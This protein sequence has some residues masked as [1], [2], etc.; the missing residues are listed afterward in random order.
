MGRA[1]CIS[2]L[3]MLLLTVADSAAIAQQK[4][5]IS[6]ESF[7]WTIE[8][9]PLVFQG[10]VT[11]VEVILIT[12]KEV[13]GVGNTTAQIP[14]TEVTMKIEKI[15]AGEYDGD[16]IRIILPEGETEKAS[17]GPAGVARM[18]VNVGDHA[19]VAFTLDS[20]GTGLN[21]LDRDER[22]FRMEGTELIPYRQ[23]LYLAVDK[24][25]EVMAKK[26]KER[27]IT[28]VFK[29]SDLICTGTVTQLID[30][31]SRSRK[32]LVSIDETLKGKAEESEICV[33]LSNVFLPSK[34]QAP[35]F[36][37]ML[38]LKKDNSGYRPVAGVNGY[39]VM[40]GERLTRG[41]STPV[42][43]TASQLKCAIKKWKKAE[44]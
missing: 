44:R 38:F 6:Q 26:A 12:P 9:E 20:Q 16:A 32:L 5:P 2:L 21:V 10:M 15:I 13:F 25:L 43:M 22:F 37:V 1:L 3:A 34:I 17:G 18:K 41:H 23:E 36:R 33:D 30:W 35:G 8:I 4:R 11:K 7:E 39:Y 31:D 42:R 28:E 27:E 14:V 19:V 24:P 40:D 29:A